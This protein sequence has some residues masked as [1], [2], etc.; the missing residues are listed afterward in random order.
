MSNCLGRTERVSKFGSAFSFFASASKTKLK[1]TNRSPQGDKCTIYLWLQG[2]KVERGLG[3]SRAETFVPQSP[4]RESGKQRWLGDPV[5]PCVFWVITGFWYSQRREGPCGRNRRAGAC[6]SL[7]PDTPP[8]LRPP[9]PSPLIHSHL[10]CQLQ[11]VCFNMS[12][13]NRSL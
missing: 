1:R 8:P 11:C 6:P 10:L 13:P 12:E 3:R 4:E 2:E 9:R 7:G 5:R